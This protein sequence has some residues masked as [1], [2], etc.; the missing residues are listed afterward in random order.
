MKANYIILSFVAVLLISITVI[1][2]RLKKLYDSTIFDFNVSGLN[3]TSINIFGTSNV[4]ITIDLIVDNSSNISIKLRD[5]QFE[6]FYGGLKLASSKNIEEF[7]IGKDKKS[8]KKVTSTLFLKSETIKF[9]KDVIKGTP[10]EIK[11]Y[12]RVRILG[13]RFRF[14]YKYKIDKNNFK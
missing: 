10:K 5:I 2:V 12:T 14:P 4:D 3:I 13:I 6:A 1:V 9:I 7:I 8:V 11:I